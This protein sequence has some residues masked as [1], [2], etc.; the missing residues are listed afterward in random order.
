MKTDNT[1]S[2]GLPFRGCGRS[3]LRLPAVS[4]GLWH[5]FGGVDSH[6]A[7]RAMLLAAYER[8]V[9]HFDLAN[10]YG[11]PPGSAEETFG[12]VLRDDLANHRDQMVI[13]TK[14]GFDMWSGPYG[15]GGS[16]KHLL[17]S[18]DQ[19]LQ[20][21]GVDYVD[22]FYSHCPD[23]STPLHETVGALVSAVTSGKALYVGLSNYSADATV[24]AAK[25]LSGEGV[26]CL[27]YQGAYSMMQRGP[28]AGLLDAASTAG[29]GFVAFSPLAQGLLS[30]RYLRDD[31]PAD[32]RASKPHGFLQREQVTP[33]ALAIARELRQLAQQRG[34]TLAQM[35][36]AWLLKDERVSSVIVGASS[37]EQLNENLDCVNTAGFA[38]EEIDAIERVLASA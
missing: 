37:V 19:S 13:T 34:Q 20:R 5:N 31:L 16:R 8:G 10:N 3:G 25:L 28:E 12:R 2:N 4:L 23:P 29:M 7:G 30:D 26:A 1:G 14:A 36:L 24:E 38:Q 9:T 21:M 32:S 27:V 15:S 33:R 18:L 22:I 17:A 35:A 11:P 6:A